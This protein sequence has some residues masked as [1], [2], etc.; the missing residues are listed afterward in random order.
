LTVGTAAP[1]LC[2]RMHALN[3]ICLLSTVSL[4]L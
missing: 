4:L 3:H 1:V 2:L